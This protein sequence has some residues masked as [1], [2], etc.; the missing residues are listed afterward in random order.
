VGFVPPTAGSPVEARDDI[1][2]RT[3]LV[4]IAALYHRAFNERDFEVWRE[5]FDDDVE[6]VIDGMTLR[7]ADAAVAYGVASVTQF[8]GLRIGSERVIAESGDTVVTEI[9]MLNGDPES[10]HFRRQGTTCEICRVRDGR[11]VSCRSYYMAEPDGEDAVRVPARGE[12]ARI[13]E[14]QAALRRVATLV[15]RDVSQDEVFAAVN[16]EV[17][18]L[19]RADPTS[20]MRFEPDDTVT[21]V[22]AWSA[23]DIDLPVGSSHPVDDALRSMRDTGRPWRWGPA[24]L[25]ATGPFVDD[26]RAAGIRAAVGVPIV[27]DGRVW[28]VQYAS[29]TTDQPFA[30]DAE[31]R[32]AAFAELVA[33]AIA[34]AQTRS[35]VRKLVAEQAALRRVATLVAREASQS[36]VF[37]AVT[38][39][40]GRLLGIEDARMVR[41]EGDETA[42]IVASWGALASELVVGTRISLEGTSASAE[43]FRTGR[44]ARIPDFAEAPGSFAAMMRALGVR[45]AVGAPIVVDGRLWGAMSTATRKPDPIPADTEARMREFTELVATAISNTEARADVGASRARIVAAADE[46]RRRVVRDLH[47]GAQQRLVHTIITLKLA[48][49]ALDGDLAAAR[50]RITEALEQAERATHELRELSH[51]IMPGVLT[52]GGLR[53]GVEALASRAPVPVD[54]D[55]SVGRLAATVEATAYF[56]VAEALTNVSKHAR[57]TGAA[58]SARIDD[59]TLRVAVRDDGVGGARAEGS[60]LVGLRDRLAALGGRLDVASPAQGGTLVAAAIP[61]SGALPAGG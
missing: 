4:A 41:Y 23:H 10:G 5:V 6:L 44:A 16:Q 27:V 18:W 19:V 17:G 43:V 53:A 34:N 30:D 61:L 37:A 28:G 58:V 12:A 22:A 36:E 13:A 2:A 49:Q 3:D 47:D 48:D 8:P 38:E 52:G 7:G 29:S 14:E 1:G 35:D 26:A 57:A 9:S 20:L 50:T 15:A 32:I 46:E 24:E 54:V 56:V 59:H 31:A 55:V 39:E 60:G 42:T 21:L 11:I 45:S 33:T 51:G 40:V 25:P